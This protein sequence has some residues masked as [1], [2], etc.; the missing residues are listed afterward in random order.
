MTGAAKNDLYEMIGPGM[1]G[2]A[3]V[4]A[5]VISGEIP[6]R[7]DM[8]AYAQA[9]LVGNLASSGA[10]IADSQGGSNLVA[11][12]RIGRSADGW[13]YVELNGMV[14]SGG[15]DRA[16][17]MLIDR[18]ATVISIFAIATLANGCIGL[19]NETTSNS[20]TITWAALYYSL[21]LAGAAPS[22]HLR[23]QI[24]GRWGSSG[25]S[26]AAGAAMLQEEVYS[27]DGRYGGTSLGGTAAGAQASSS[28]GGQYVVDAHRLAI[29]PKGGKPAAHLVRV[30][31]DYSVLTPSRS[32][33][34]LCKVEVDVGGVRE[35]CLSGR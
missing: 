30:V 8:A 35:R 17:I 24:V 2:R 31:E 16:R 32:M 21:K 20:N 4:C 25:G 11:D 6:S 7:G 29:F 28:G 33:V 27:P 13:R 1:A 23:E 12:R 18:G 5:I 14:T 22:D 19:S 26:I 10:G 3:G 34:R 9:L 15:V